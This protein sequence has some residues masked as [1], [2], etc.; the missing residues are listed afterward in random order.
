MLRVEGRADRAGIDFG[1]L[2]FFFKWGQGSLLYT[3]SLMCPVTLL[4]QPHEELGPQVCVLHLFLILQ[5][6]KNDLV[7]VSK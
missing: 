5:S 4:L 7:G 2:I 6:C 3:L 1:Y